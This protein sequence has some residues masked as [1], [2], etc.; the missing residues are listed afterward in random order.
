MAKLPNV[1]SLKTTINHT[2]EE[3]QNLGTLRNE[4]TSIRSTIY[5]S[6]SSM[7]M[8]LAKSI[9]DGSEFNLHHYNIRDKNQFIDDRQHHLSSPQRAVIEAWQANG[10]RGLSEI[11]R[12]IENLTQQLAGLKAALPSPEKVAEVKA[13]LENLRSTAAEKEKEICAPYEALR[14]S[15]FDLTADL[16]DEM[17]AVHNA[18]SIGRV[19]CAE[20]KELREAYDLETGGPYNVAGLSES[21]VTS[22][23]ALMGRLISSVRRGYLPQSN[24]PLPKVD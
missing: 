11:E 19:L 6:G 12:D 5:Q 10:R 20:A 17:E 15:L 2:V 3:L 13:H 21:E 7:L 24:W 8:L 4:L 16:P 9:T 18:K 22:L 14:Q 1:K 23:E